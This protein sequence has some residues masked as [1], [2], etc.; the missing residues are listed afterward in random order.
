MNYVRGTGKKSLFGS[1]R[2]VMV[3]GAGGMG[4]AKLL[5]LLDGHL[6]GVASSF[7]GDFN[8]AAELTK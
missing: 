3:I 2:S 4:S 5:L 8:L 1:L 6:K 7:N